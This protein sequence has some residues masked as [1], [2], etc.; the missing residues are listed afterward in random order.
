MISLEC[1]QCS[2][3]FV[4]KKP[5]QGL[6][7]F[8]SRKCVALSQ[9]KPSTGVF[10]K[11]KRNPNTKCLSCEKPIYRR[12][13]NIKSGPVFCSLRCNGVFVR[14]PDVLCVVC[15]IVITTKRGSV[16]SRKCCSRACSNKARTGISYHQGSP[17]DKAKKNQ[18]LKD[19]L[20]RSRG[21]RCEHC[22]HPNIPIL[23]VHHIK[24]RSEGGSDDLDNLLLVCPNCHTTIHHGVQTFEEFKLLH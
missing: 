14:K 19:A 12:P 21:P 17:N 7:V 11:E 5:P 10:K 2:T 8:C 13:K 22:Q 6:R 15:K 24:E 4:R 3:P 9:I 1:H 23:H 16:R 20:V 18:R